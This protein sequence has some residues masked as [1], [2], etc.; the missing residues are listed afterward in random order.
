M[1]L[2]FRESRSKFSK[3][4]PEPSTSEGMTTD[5]NSAGE[6]D[7]IMKKDKQTKKVVQLQDSSSV[8]KLLKPSNAY[9]MVKSKQI[10]S[11]KRGRLSMEKVSRKQAGFENSSDHCPVS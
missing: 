3:I 9:F 10:G 5:G 4:K 1:P 7:N 2:Q 11:T 8:C 6:S